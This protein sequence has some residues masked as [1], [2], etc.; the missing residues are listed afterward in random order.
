MNWY[1]CFLLAAALIQTLNVI[2]SIATGK[3]LEQIVIVSPPLNVGLTEMKCLHFCYEYFSFRH[4]TSTKAAWG[5][6]FEFLVIRNVK[7]YMLLWPGLFSEG[8]PKLLS[9]DSS[10]PVITT[11]S[12]CLSKWRVSESTLIQRGGCGT[13]VKCRSCTENQSNKE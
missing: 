8:T 13:C 10:N 12:L 2:Y 5:T 3:A 9:S 4:K 7:F 11:S 6:Q 1:C